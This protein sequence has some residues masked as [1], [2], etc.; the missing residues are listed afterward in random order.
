MVPAVA[1]DEEA[2]DDGAAL[3]AS[4]PNATAP[5]SRVIR[6]RDNRAE[7]EE[8]ATSSSHTVRGPSGIVRFHYRRDGSR[9]DGSRRCL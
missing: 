3:F 2:A 6:I 8:D 4:V 7:E 9:R 1:A 5:D